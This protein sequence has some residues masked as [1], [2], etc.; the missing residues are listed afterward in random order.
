[1]CVCWGSEDGEAGSRYGGV[2]CV[3]VDEWVNGYS[4]SIPRG[5]G[6]TV[7]E[8]K[9]TGSEHIHVTLNTIQPGRFTLAIQILFE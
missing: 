7:R 2:V 1:M 9:V 6:L 8:F 5:N 4:Q 3:C